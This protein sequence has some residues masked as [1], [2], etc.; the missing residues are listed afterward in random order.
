MKLIGFMWVEDVEGF[1]EWQK[2][3]QEYVILTVIPNAGTDSWVFV[4][5]SYEG[6]DK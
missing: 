2:E 5:Y 1:I 6:D 3:H 4:T